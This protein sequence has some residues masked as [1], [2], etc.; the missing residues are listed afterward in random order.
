V[1]AVLGV[2][3][4]RC[5]LSS[6]YAV[7]GVCCTRCMLS[8][9]YAVLGVCCPRWM[10]YSVYAVVGVCCT[11]YMLYSV[12]AVLAV[13]WTRCEPWIMAGRDRKGWPNFAALG[14]GRVEDEKE[15]DERRWSKSS[16]A[17][18]NWRISCASEFTIHDMAGTSRHLPCNYNHTRSSQLNPACL[19]PDSSYPLTSST[20]FSSSSPIALCLIHN[21]AIVAEP[22]VK[23]CLS[24]SP[25]PDHQLTPS[26]AYSE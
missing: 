7:L 23:P 9:V 26:T 8:S 4:T 24:I 10:L 16:W 22:N 19:T 15:R 17:T 18:V 3:C 6:V 25:C 13:C 12:Y 21:S 2:C 20:S 1:Y 11:P 5:M 14:D